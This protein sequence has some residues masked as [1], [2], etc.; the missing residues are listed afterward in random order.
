[1]T[2]RL[3]RAAHCSLFSSTEVLIMTITR[4]QRTRQRRPARS[5]PVR[6]TC[7]PQL[8]VLESRLTPA[9]PIITTQPSSQTI[10]TNQT[11]TLGV[12]ATG[13]GLT[14]QWY[15]AP[16]NVFYANNVVSYVPGALADPAWDIPSAALGGLNPVAG[17]FAEGHGGV[18]DFYTTPFDPTF[19]PS[20][21]VE[22]GGGG[23][24]IL[25]LGQTASTDG[26]T[27]GV[28]T[29]I[30]LNDADYPN[31]T[32]T[33]PATFFNSFLR[34]ADV[35]VSADGV[36]WGDLGN[37]SFS[38]PSNYYAG[39]A[40]DPEGLSPG[41]GPTADPGEP[42]LG[43]LS[44]FDGQNWQGT[45]N[46]LNGS[47]GGTWLN[48][49]GVTDGHGNPITGV[50]YIQFVVPS[51][52]LMMVDAVVGLNNSMSPI[53]GATGPTYTT[54]TLMNNADYWV[55][56][57]DS[58]HNTTLSNMATLVVNPPPSILTQP[59]SQTIFSNQTAT[60]SVTATGTGLTY[61]WY[62]GSMGDTTNLI[63]GATGASYTTP[64]LTSATNYWVQVTDGNANVI[65]SNTA[66][67]GVYAPP[68]IITP[69]SGQ[70]IF[71][72]QTASMSVTASGTGLSYQ[73]YVG[74]SGDTSGPI[75]GATG[76]TYTTPALTATTRYWVQ[77]TDGGG[78]TANSS[79]ATITV[80]PAPTITTPPS[81]HSVFNGQ[82][83]ILSVTATGTGLTYQ[84]YVGSSGDTTNLI[85]GATGTS[86]TTPSLT[87]AT[88]Y[89]VQVT[90]GGGNTIN[91]NTATITINPAPSIPTQPANQTIFT[92]ETTKLTV[93][94]TGVGLSYQWYVGSSG[95][96]TDPVPGATGSSYT[97][98]ALTGTTSYWVRVTDGGGSTIDSSTATITVSAMVTPFAVTEDVGGSSEVKVYDAS[99]QQIQFDFYAYGPSVTGGVRVALGDVTGDRVPDI[100]TVPG[101]GAAAEV[102]VF[103]GV[104]GALIRDFY[105]FPGS[106]TTGFFVAAGDL[107]NSG[108][109]DIV[110][111]TD[112]GSA[113]EVRAFNGTTTT[114][115][116]DFFPYGAF[117]GGVRVAVG[118]VNGDGFGDII[119]GTGPGTAA[120]VRAFSGA[121][122]TVLR[123]FYA[124]PASYQGGI[125]V[126]AGDVNG[127]SL[128]DIIVG[129]D[130]GSSEVRVF[131]GA[132]G[133]T[134][135]DFYAYAGSFQG[136]V[137][138]G[139][140]DTDGGG[141]GLIL[142]SP[143]P[144]SSGSSSAPV[145]SLVQELDAV[146]VADVDSFFA[147]NPSFNGGL[148]VGGA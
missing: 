106:A 135:L 41:V 148:F 43:S 72:G 4:H 133:T 22:I 33:S 132:S 54:S 142:T 83:A 110:V 120:H 96:T 104:T 77:V 1:M 63:T 103:D 46:V 10:T 5:K 58:S 73:W 92:G 45:L 6:A 91:S 115:L 86:Y 16:E 57:T 101:P 28:H 146:T 60:M 66:T 68:S 70:T 12:A 52:E 87:S 131:D 118:D 100:I 85:A 109:A 7:R 18:T 30:G 67:I 34:Q 17:S 127:A 78:N 79:T 71:S 13:T 107:R 9:G 89:W 136:G 81:S 143:G 98:P 105:A 75:S 25:K 76:S 35:L 42:F 62:V 129:A 140:A 123:D 27:I 3:R 113:G 69:P 39:S 114:M 23:S 88:S 55:S 26:Y 137:R 38:N 90:D 99:T 51:G 31:G 134:L 36:N 128:A 93:V 20:E 121:D 139:F 130:T 61:Q 126:A 50:N 122:G 138:V 59:S 111:S 15:T 74:S 95:N 24:L 47:A 56:V 14:Y 49:K 21:M 97:S 40:T 145:G 11:A 32:N 124:L 64:S 119:T 53:P 144:V 82:T 117:T 147:F 80:H 108:V 116:Y 29:G 112:A 8:E 65:N 2:Q 125:N 141:G 44:S 48:L 37:M 19:D 84:W 94:A 102:R